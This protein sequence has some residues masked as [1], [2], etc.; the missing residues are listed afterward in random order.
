L[1]RLRAL[2]GGVADIQEPGGFLSGW[3]WGA[4]GL[5]IWGQW[6]ANLAVGNPALAINESESVNVEGC[7]GPLSVP[8]PV[9][10]PRP[11]LG[12]L[13][14]FGTAADRRIRHRQWRWPEVLSDA[15]SRQEVPMH[16]SV[17][18]NICLPAILITAMLIFAGGLSDAAAKP[19]PKQQCLNNYADCYGG[20]PGQ[21]ENKCTRACE[22]GFRACWGR[23]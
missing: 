2:N 21:G 3:F 20:C 4:L 17:G 23:R 22:R 18:L 16:K 14:G 11:D 1:S 6:M 19:K 7:F 15:R 12:R 8:R 5:R 13:A 10:V 9:S